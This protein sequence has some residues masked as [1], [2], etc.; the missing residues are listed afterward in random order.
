M[1]RR[2]LPLPAVATLLQAYGG[3]PGR[4]QACVVDPVLA[5]TRAPQVSCLMPTR[6]RAS[7]ARTAIACWQAQTWEA[8]ELVIVE[9][10]GSGELA[11]WVEGLGDARIRYHRVPEGSMILGEQRNET[12]RLARGEYVAIWDDDDY[13]H[14]LRL[15]LQMQAALQTGSQACWL[16]RTLTWRAA[17][18]QL[19]TTRV[20]ATE[21]T[22]VC[23]ADTMPRFPALPRGE[24]TPVKYALLDQA[25][26]IVLDAPALYVYCLHEHNTWSDGH[27]SFLYGERSGEWLGRDYDQAMRDIAAWPALRHDARLAA[28]LAELDAR[29]T[30]ASVWERLN[31]G[32][33]R[34]DQWRSGATR[35]DQAWK[36]R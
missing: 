2:V 8:R 4:W 33:R 11:E 23:R 20:R 13:S 32:K 7:M 3:A 10:G 5:P 27:F 12:L 36:N 26:A 28:H 6:A 18:R 21:N 14:P 17:R 24:D 35:L 30:A 22:L 15:Q 25:Q 19:W 9:Q 34:F 29:P 16:A 31:A 1:H